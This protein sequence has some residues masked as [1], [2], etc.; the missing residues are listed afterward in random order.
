MCTLVESARDPVSAFIEQAI[1][2]KLLVLD[3]DGSMPLSDFRSSYKT[4]CEGL[5]VDFKFT[6]QDYEDSSKLDVSL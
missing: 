5:Y 2:S 3:Q 6:Q 4:Y 1:K